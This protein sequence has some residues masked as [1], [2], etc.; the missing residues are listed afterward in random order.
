LFILFFENTSNVSYKLDS[1][2]PMLKT[3]A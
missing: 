1:E 2:V 3:L